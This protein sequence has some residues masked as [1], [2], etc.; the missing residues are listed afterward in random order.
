MVGLTQFEK[1]DIVCGVD[2]LSKKGCGLHKCRVQRGHK[3]KHRCRSCS[4]KA[5]LT[6][7][8]LIERNKI[9]G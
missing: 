1:Q 9:D 7:K 3:S 5:V 8:E 4:A 6:K 2:W